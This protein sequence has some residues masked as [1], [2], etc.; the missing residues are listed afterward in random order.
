MFTLIAFKFAIEGEWK[1][2]F[3]ESGTKVNQTSDGVTKSRKNEDNF[4][5]EN[6]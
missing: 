4:C 2:R 1:H 6:Q 5:T 3:S